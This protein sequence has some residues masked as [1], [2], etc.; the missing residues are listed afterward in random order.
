MITVKIKLE[1]PFFDY[2]SKRILREK[3]LELERVISYILSHNVDY[4]IYL[5]CNQCKVE[6]EW[7]YK[8]GNISRD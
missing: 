8:D 1:E 4:E 3:E 2:D 7:K 6:H 5:K